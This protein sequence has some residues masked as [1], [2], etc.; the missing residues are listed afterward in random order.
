MSLPPNGQP[1]ADEPRYGVRLPGQEN[2]PTQP[3]YGQ[4]APQS[5]ERPGWDA[6]PQQPADGI[7][8]QPSG[9]YTGNPQQPGYPGQQGYPGQPGF[10]QAPYGQPGFGYGAP[11]AVPPQPSTARWASLLLWIG[12]GL[13]LIANVVVL[14][15]TDRAALRA[16]ALGSV[17]SEMRSQY[18]SI[19]TDS[20]LTT[21]L[22]IA[23]VVL[24][25]VSGFAALVAWL[26]NR[27]S[28]AWRIVGT[29]CGALAALS[30]FASGGLIGILFGL[31]AVAIVVLWWVPQ[32]SAWFRAVSAAKAAGLRG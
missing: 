10:Q 28:N 29:V 9:I 3:Q 23:A 1:P 7:P 12:A 31:L 20:M 32:S 6:A 13:Y 24:A 19:L 25:L 14:F 21:S 5:N 8:V 30:N 16:Q 27:G 2:Q 15:A 17:P 26:T 22:V 4:P 18:E 11:V